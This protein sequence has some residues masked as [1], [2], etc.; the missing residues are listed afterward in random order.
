MVDPKSA[1]H[2]SAGPP[3]GA[4]GPAPPKVDATRVLKASQRKKT[5]RARKA[6]TAKLVV[7]R[8]DVP[9]A[10]LML[11][12]PRTIIGRD[13]DR[14]DVVLEDDNVSRQHASVSR[15][16]TGLFVL[17]DLGSR[18]GVWVSGRRVERRTLIN[19]DEFTIGATSFAF[20]ELDA[21]GQ[22]VEPVQVQPPQNALPVPPAAEEAAP[23]G[24]PQGEEE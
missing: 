10:D 14:A 11:N 21:Q 17:H 20:Q 7:R 19:G 16:D 12:R 18:N 1:R 4:A 13:R 3:A 23:H 8:P 6:A 2:N 9:P 15:E 24:E 5:L 22:P